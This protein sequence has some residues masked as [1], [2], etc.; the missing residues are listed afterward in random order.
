M[1]ICHWEFDG[2][3]PGLDLRH[4][5]CYQAILNPSVVQLPK[6]CNPGIWIIIRSFPVKSASQ[7]GG[8]SPNFWVDVIFHLRKVGQTDMGVIRELAFVNGIRFKSLF[9]VF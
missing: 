1:C 2:I 5:A 3:F 4:Q 6:N 7:W 9:K 8:L